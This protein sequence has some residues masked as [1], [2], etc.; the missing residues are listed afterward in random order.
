MLR[1]PT[2][3]GTVGETGVYR[4]NLAEFGL[5]QIGAVAIF[6]DRV[7]SGGTGAASGFDL[8]FVRLSSTLTDDPAAATTV[9]SSGRVVGSR[10]FTFI[11]NLGFTDSQ[12]AFRAG[13][14]QPWAAG[15]DPAR[16]VG[17]LF[18]TVAGSINSAVN[19]AA[20]TLGTR[21]GTVAGTFGSLS[22]GEGGA[23][24]FALG[25]PVEATSLYL[26]F[27]DAGG[28]NEPVLVDAL[29]SGNHALLPRGLT[30]RGTT[31]GDQIAL[32][33]ERN[34]HLGTGDDA[35]N[36]DA[37]E[38]NISTGAGND[39]IAGAGGDDT[40]F[41]GPGN[42]TALYRGSRSEYDIHVTIGRTIVQDLV[43]GRDGRDLLIDVENLAFANP[44]VYRFHNTVAGG[45][46][47][48]TNAA[49]RDGILRD[50]PALRYEGIGY[51]ALDQG[52]PGS[53][54]VYRF[55]NTVAGGHLFT[56]DAAE[57]DAI[58]ARLPG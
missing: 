51:Y 11:D 15:D 55:H 40:I 44:A 32:G 6:D 28:G 34:V 4:M 54:P 41:G 25:S 37:G 39:R 23:I 24:S 8:D 27:G 30:L 57:R 26:Y 20:A 3:L 31:A 22:L 45:H 35:V 46:L 14:V 33:F 29:P 18:G 48:T 52:V 47:F 38:D 1:K 9:A 50:L 43:A 17:D 53:A 5:S 13:Y 49:E 21:D 12:L 58:I 19:L 42:D 56:T 36:G 16:N 7:V 10:I 2:Y